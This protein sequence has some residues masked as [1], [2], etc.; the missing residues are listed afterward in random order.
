MPFRPEDAGDLLHMVSYLCILAKIHRSSSSNGISFKT[1]TILAMAMLLRY[2]EV[3][4]D[5]QLVDAVYHKTFGAVASDL[6]LSKLIQLFSRDRLVHTFVLK[7]YFL[8]VSVA[9]VANMRFFTART[10]YTQPGWE[11]RDWLSI[12]LFVLMPATILTGTF[13]YFTE[14]TFA[15][16]PFV[17]YLSYALETFALLPQKAL[18]LNDSY[19]YSATMARVA[20][21]LIY[22]CAW[23]YRLLHG[24]PV[25]SL[26]PYVML[27][28]LPLLQIFFFIEPFLWYTIRYSNWLVLVSAIL[29]A[30]YLYM[31][32]AL[33]M[34]FIPGLQVGAMMVT[35]VLGRFSIFVGIALLY[36][37]IAVCRKHLDS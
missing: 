31:G 33:M 14:S 16:L 24:H 36:N 5:F 35:L 26:A 3:F 27:R 9:I 17:K 28:L 2:C 1:Q 34:K 12:T 19:V 13:V 29:Y 11:N 4:V 18:G 15:W 8:V 7:C 25:E 10:S 6:S 30:N 32:G 37:A 22:V 23:I 21:R 20:Y